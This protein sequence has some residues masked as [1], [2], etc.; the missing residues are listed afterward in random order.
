MYLVVE[1][2]VSLHNAG[3][4]FVYMV[5]LAPSNQTFYQVNSKSWWHI[6][7]TSLN[8]VHGAQNWINGWILPWFKSASSAASMGK[9]EFQA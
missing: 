5:M 9:T 8:L 7:W 6:T 2:S 4:L 1:L 3:N